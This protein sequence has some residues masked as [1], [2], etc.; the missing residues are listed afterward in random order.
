M[1]L[2]LDPEQPDAVVSA[3]RELL[4][5]TAPSPDPWWQAGVDEA[6][7]PGDEDVPR[8]GPSASA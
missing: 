4:R 2:T 1:E 5:S 7:A 3:V 8:D 6:L